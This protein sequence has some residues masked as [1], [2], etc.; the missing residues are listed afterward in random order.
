ML[1][2]V[3]S[4]YSNG[5]SEGRGSAR[6][7]KSD[8]KTLRLVIR[9]LTQHGLKSSNSCVMCP[10]RQRG[11]LLVSRFSFFLYLFRKARRWQRSGLTMTERTERRVRRRRQTEGTE[12]LD[13]CRP[14]AIEQSFRREVCAAPSRRTESKRSH[15][16]KSG[17]EGGTVEL[18]VRSC[19]FLERCIIRLEE[20]MFQNTETHRNLK[21]LHLSDNT[22]IYWNIHMEKMRI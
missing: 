13:F 9:I 20:T 1:P 3:N 8:W 19:G 21:V 2:Q 12:L 16:L 18:I 22:V 6:I 14:A 17:T 4:K 15:W 7:K 10:S 5:E 11:S